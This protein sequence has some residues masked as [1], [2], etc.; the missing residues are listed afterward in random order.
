MK[1]GKNRVLREQFSPERFRIWIRILFPIPKKGAFTMT[2]KQNFILFMD[3]WLLV[4]P[5]LV[6]QRGD[7]IR[8]FFSCFT[9]PHLIVWFLDYW[10]MGRCIWTWWQKYVHN[11][12]VFWHS[13]EF[14]NE[15]DIGKGWM[16]SMCENKSII[17]KGIFIWCL[18][19]N[20]NK[21]IESISKFVLSEQFSPGYT[22]TLSS[23]IFLAVSCD[24][25]MKFWFM[26]RV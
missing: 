12:A 13:I 22:A 20:K 6:F 17:Y 8:V 14:M 15:W 9:T 19:I 1:E 23:S 16:S 24:H 7:F 11:F 21:R 18:H 25:M 10:S 2:A 26:E 3:Q 5:S 4:I